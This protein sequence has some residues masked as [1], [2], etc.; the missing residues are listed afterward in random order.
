MARVSPLD[1]IDQSAAVLV[2]LDGCLLSGD[3]LAPG[4]RE[5]ADRAGERLVIVSNNS[6][7]TAAEMS[8]VL[9]GLGIAV[10]AT[11][12]VLAGALAVE[13]IAAD[14]PGGRLLALAGPSITAYAEDQGLRLVEDE[15]EVVLLGRDLDFSYPRLARAARALSAGAALV[16]SNPDTAHPDADG[17][18]VPETGALLAALTAI[19]PGAAPRVIGKPQ[20]AMFMAALSRMGAR[21]WEAVMIGD[22]PRTDRVGAALLGISSLL[23]GP[24]PEARAESLSVLLRQAGGRA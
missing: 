4:A 1:L 24:A 2:D 10:P 21:P 22:N 23:V 14:W 19:V 5:L 18:P 13:T 11:R 12:V 9:A 3:G 16:A 6:T 7:A 8:A 15:A 17:A 20:P